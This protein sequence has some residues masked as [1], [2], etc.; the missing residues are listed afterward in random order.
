MCPVIEHGDTAI[1]GTSLL[2][3][4][5]KP[6]RKVETYLSGGICHL[7]MKWP[8]D[9]TAALAMVSDGPCRLDDPEAPSVN[10][11]REQYM[12]DGEMEVPVGTPD[13]THI[14]LYAIY[15]DARGQK[16]PSRGVEI[17]LSSQFR[18][19]LDHESMAPENRFLRD[20]SGAIENGSDRER[21]SMLQMM[22]SRA[23]ANSD[24]D[25]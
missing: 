14:S 25:A 5:V 9:A 3:A 2:V 11:S 8:D 10:V 20:L 19:Q 16:Y 18:S 7:R 23:S 1:C 6:F 12:R 22:A 17:D 13:R 4:N 15:R 21:L 24:A